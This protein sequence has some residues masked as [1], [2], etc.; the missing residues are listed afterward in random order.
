[1]FANIGGGHE[2]GEYQEFSMAASTFLQ[3][4]DSE[5]FLRGEFEL[6]DNGLVKMGESLKQ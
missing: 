1:V 5:D 3:K 2:N 6:G 4:L